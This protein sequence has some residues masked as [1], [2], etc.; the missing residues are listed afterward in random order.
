MLQEEAEE[1]TQSWILQGER[2]DSVF[3]PSDSSNEHFRLHKRK[4]EMPDFLQ[5]FNE[6]NFLTEL[7]TEQGATTVVSTQVSFTK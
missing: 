3:K 7:M 6:D 5:Q 2:D 1:M 4:K